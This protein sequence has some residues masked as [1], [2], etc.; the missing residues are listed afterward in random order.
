MLLRVCCE[1]LV[2]CFGLKFHVSGNKVELRISPIHLDNSKY[3]AI[4]ATSRKVFNSWEERFCPQEGIKQVCIQQNKPLKFP[5]STGRKGRAGWVQRQQ[6]GRDA[7]LHTPECQVL[8]WGHHLSHGNEWPQLQLQLGTAAH[9]NV[10]SSTRSQKI[11]WSFS[12]LMLSPTPASPAPIGPV[13]TPCA[14]P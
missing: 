14:G 8:C 7:L 11:T 1:H 2:I 9:R 6:G 3:S 4:P 10:P 12:S 5:L 13:R